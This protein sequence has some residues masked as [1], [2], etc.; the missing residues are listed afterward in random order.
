MKASM[1]TWNIMGREPVQSKERTAKKERIARYGL[2][3]CE[4]KDIEERTAR[5][6]LLGSKEKTTKLLFFPR[7]PFISFRSFL[8]QL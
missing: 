3:G 6:G 5:E 8:V 1:H 2:L 7:C 4:G